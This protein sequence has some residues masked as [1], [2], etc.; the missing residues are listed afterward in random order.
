MKITLT[1]NPATLAIVVVAS[2]TLAS[3]CR[4]GKKDDSTAG[5]PPPS[6]SHT[7]TTT[8]TTTT[9][10][11]GQLSM[12]GQT[13]SVMPLYKESVDIGK[14]EVD[15]GSVRVKKVVKTETVNQPIELRHE[16]IVI[17]RVPPSESASAPSGGAF[18]EQETV[19]H[20]TKEEPVI[21]K[22]TTS[23]GQIVLQGRTE[24]EQTN[25]QAQ[26]RSEDV[27]V[28]KS[29]N[30]ENVTI[31]PNIQQSGAAMGSA[32]SSSAQATGQ[33]SSGPTIT[34]VDPTM[35]NSITAGN[36]AGSSAQFSH[37]KVQDLIGE[38][39]AQCMAYNGQ[40][41]YL[42]SNRSLANLKKGASINVSGI[43]R[44]GSGGLSGKPGQALSSQPAYIDTTRIESAL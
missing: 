4:S 21:Q 39:V 32:E 13:N 23:T 42:F 25:I 40:P 12:T 30:A 43:V 26:V 6:Y 9:Q 31:G 34:V 44:S 8:T 19:I 15:A 7:T 35:L 41:I 1:N 16:E 14:R 17:E 37:L 28:V 27:A 2:A 33:A 29:D 18:Q 3:G 20:L 22:R 36:L 5:Y 10:K 24:S 11:Q 38:Q